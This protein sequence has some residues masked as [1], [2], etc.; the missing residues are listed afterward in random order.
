MSFNRRSGTGN[1]EEFEGDYTLVVFPLLKMSKRNREATAQEIG[2]ILRRTTP[3]WI[4]FNVIKGFLNIKFALFWVGVLKSIVKMKIT[5]NF[6]L[7]E[8]P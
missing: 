3:M 7:P 6:L 2:H 4:R 8:R 5:V 1:K